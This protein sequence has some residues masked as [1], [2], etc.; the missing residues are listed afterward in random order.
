MITKVRKRDG[1]I[2]LFNKDKIVEAIFKG[3]TSVNKLDHALA[4]KL[5]D[6]VEKELDEKFNKKETPHV[7]DIQDLIEKALIKEGLAEVAKSFILYR[8]QRTVIREAKQSLIGKIDDSDL[9]ITSLKIAEAKYLLKDNDGNIIETPNQMFS[10]VAKCIANVEKKY[11]KDEQYA[12]DLEKKFYEIISNLEFLPSGRILAHAGTESTSLASSIAIPIEDSLEDIFTALLHAV[13]LQKKTVGTGFNFSK[14]RPRG[15]R[16]SENYGKAVGPV[17][18]MHIFNSASELIKCRGNR[19]SANMAIVR[20]LAGNALINTIKGKVPI[21]DLVNK[22][23]YVYC[24]DKESKNVKVRK[25]TSYKTG[26]KKE[27]WKLTLDN[28][29]FLIATPDHKIML[30]NGEYKELKDLKRADSL[31]ALTK[32]ID[33]KGYVWIGATGKDNAILEHVAVAEMILGRYPKTSLIKKP[34]NEDVHHVD[35]DKTNN[36]PENLQVLTCSEHAKQHSEILDKFR[37]AIADKRRGRKYE[38]VYDKEKVRIWK[39][40]MSLARRNKPTWNKYPEEGINEIINLYRSG[41]TNTKE[42]SQKTRISVVTINRIIKANNLRK[43][44]ITL[45]CLPN[46]KVKNVKF[47]GYEDIY[48]MTIPAFHNYAVENIFVHNCDHPDIIDFIGAKENQNYLNNF[49]ISVGLTDKFLDAVRRNDDYD[50]VDPLTEKIV[51]KLN[52]RKIFDMVISTAWKNGEPGLLFL[53]SINRKNPTPELGKLDC[54]SS[55]AEMAL[56]PYEAAFLGSINLEKFVKDNEINYDKLREVIK[57]AIRFLDNVID[58]C[59]YPIE[60]INEITKANRK[61]G[62]GIMGFADLLYSLQIPYNSEKG[63]ETAEELIKFIQKTAREESSNLGVE[64]GNFPNYKKSIFYKKTAMRNATVT[65][66]APSGSISILAETSNS[67]EPNFAIGYMRNVLG[68]TQ[69][70]FV[71]KHFEKMAKEK[72]IYNPTMIKTVVEQGSLDN[73]EEIPEKI[74]KVF[75][76]SHQISPE[77]HVKM[78]AVFQ[79]HIDNAISKTINFPFTA[80]LQDVEKGYF[81]AHELGCK[82]ITIYRDGSRVEQVINLK[83]PSK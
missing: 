4:E 18:F 57:L 53:D 13:T 8:Y 6:I 80:A 37:E 2:V 56:Y 63:L 10:R 19:K 27:V 67:I 66:I 7:E 38:E 65:A 78:Q 39:Q 52:A 73:I 49:N 30:R 74:K 23:A 75:V 76:V 36:N 31:M 16:T 68:N 17:S 46:H 1:R 77:W 51:S 28:D 72:G 9:S 60:K 29:D 33:N 41:V 35:E 79:K 81:K 45:E 58:V 34:E 22:T 59:E 43:K 61:I 14:I 42:I 12:R 50:L 25:A 55:C 3:M 26:E 70:T 21:K 32:Y 83:E 24:Y 15:S 82:G 20:C 71:N 62:L 47:Y 11:D 44:A 64:K 40:K 5:A 48:D 54:T 69:I